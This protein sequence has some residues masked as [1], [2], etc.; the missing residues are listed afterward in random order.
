MKTAIIHGEY[1]PV[2][3]AASEK[4]DADIAGGRTPLM[5]EHREH[6]IVHFVRLYQID[7][8]IARDALSTYNSNKPMCAGLGPDVKKRL[9]QLGLT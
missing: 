8:A 1:T 7:P 6:M 2:L 5:L 4:L 3:K 9:D